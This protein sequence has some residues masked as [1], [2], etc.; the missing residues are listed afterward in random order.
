MF[1]NDKDAPDSGL[2]SFLEN[3]KPKPFGGGNKP[4]HLHDR[5]HLLAQQPLPEFSHKL[6]Q[7][8]A[9][10][11]NIN[12]G[13]SV[14]AVVLDRAIPYRLK[15]METFSAVTSPH[16][17]QT[18]G[19]GSM[20]FSATNQWHQVAFFE[21]P[22]GTKLSA[23]LSSGQR[24]HEHQMI[25]RVLSP[26]L[27]VL[28]IYRDKEMVHGSLNTDTILTGDTT[29][30]MESASSPCGYFQHY[31]FEPL[32]RMM[33]DQSARG[34]S[35]ERCD[36]YAVAVVAFEM[37][38]GLD[39]LRKLT[40][41]EFIDRALDIGTYHLFSQGLDLSDN[42]ADF[43][44]GAMSDNLDERWD[45]E[46]FQNWL[47]GK[48][49][50]MIVP[51]TPREATRPLNY[52]GRD[53]FSK[54]SLAHTFHKT[55]RTTL[56]DIREIRLDR[57]FEMSMHKPEMADRV[58]RILRIGGSGSSEKINNDMMTRLIGLLDPIGPLRTTNY[59]VRVEGMGIMLAD[60]FKSGMPTEMHELIDLIEMDT[61]NYWA[62][63]T[64][65][66]RALDPAKAAY[67]SQM[68][69]RLQRAKPYLKIR[70]LGFGVERILYELN[71]NL[72]CQS[73]MIKSFNCLSIGD[74]LRAL[75]TIAPTQAKAS[76]L[77]DR[78]IAAFLACKLDLSK[79]LKIQDVGA[80]PGLSSNQ[81]LVALRILSRAQQKNDKEKYVG[82]GIWA[83]FRVEKMLTYIHNRTLRAKLI[84][85][86]KP[87]AASGDVNEVISVVVNRE[88]LATD[89]EGFNRALQKH[90]ANQKMIDDLND[91]K[92]MQ[93]MSQMLGS[94]VSSSL[95]YVVLMASFYVS[96]AKISL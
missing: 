29:M 77:I 3:F 34:V 21:K 57:W 55:W 28:K 15:L 35:D 4:D 58:E 61:P 50:N 89:Q 40:R 30:V 70:S 24:M 88:V 66:A 2:E 81:E 94:R 72:P 26:L 25:D 87:A 27:S 17:Q 20:L 48:R 68:L 16:L 95:G 47:G 96:L 60:L 74:V 73:E 76:S 78:H 8:Y 43:F 31:L 14:Y 82:L 1:G 6:G 54:R 83:A 39:H 11:D 51:P 22:V 86:L 71:S 46:H 33:A 63:L 69:W 84:A 79:E 49:Y 75:D 45:I 23:L 10:T 85:K 65:G 53:Y 36:V 91:P 7:A 44:R 38:Y 37:I 62:Y 42:M 32:E 13:K 5:F 59:S 67:L 9:A 52:R 56:K 93:R 18:L 80:V 12:E 64:D 41:E 19:N 92:R 90:K